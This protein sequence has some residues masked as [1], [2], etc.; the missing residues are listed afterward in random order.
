M[1]HERCPCTVIKLFRP[2]PPSHCTAQAAVLMN[3]QF[4]ATNIGVRHHPALSVSSWC[5]S[6]ISPHKYSE[7]HFKKKDRKSFN[8]SQA[9]NIATLLPYCIHLCVLPGGQYL[10]RRPAWCGTCCSAAVLQCAVLAGRGSAAN[11][12]SVTPRART[13]ARPRTPA[14]RTPDTRGHRGH[15]GGVCTLHQSAAAAAVVGVVADGVVVE[16]LK[17]PSVVTREWAA[18]ASSGQ[19]RQL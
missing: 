8:S 13:R 15:R 5:P 1:R 11:W 14:P 18:A 9:I 2:C 7:H 3:T 6:F 17:Q 19:T 10:Q 12:S 16:R 4:H